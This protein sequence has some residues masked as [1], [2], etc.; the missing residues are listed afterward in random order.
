[1]ALKR[2]R[3]VRMCIRRDQK[4]I[5]NIGSCCCHESLPVNVFQIPPEKLPR[6]EYSIQWVTFQ[7]G[8]KEKMRELVE[9]EERKKPL[10]SLVVAFISGII[11]P[12][13][14]KRDEVVLL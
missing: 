2:K 6:A 8:A 9:R 11:S 3:C 12:Q 5:V 14:A 4:M 7:R 13:R 1:M 10:S